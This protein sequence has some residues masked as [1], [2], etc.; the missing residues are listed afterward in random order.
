MTVKND[1]IASAKEDFGRGNRR[2]AKEP[3]H[4][5]DGDRNGLRLPMNIVTD[6]VYILAW[7]AE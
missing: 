1:A 6:E 5:L 4:Y 3:Y 7:I 2:E